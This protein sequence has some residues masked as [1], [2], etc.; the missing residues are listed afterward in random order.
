[1]KSIAAVKPGAISEQ[2]KAAMSEAGIIVI[3]MENPDDIRLIVVEPL[4]PPDDILYAAMSG[5]MDDVAPRKRFA[6]EMLVS[7]A[8]SHKQKLAKEPT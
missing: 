5:L 6:E 3:E 4:M 2:D 7:I 8:R 1:M